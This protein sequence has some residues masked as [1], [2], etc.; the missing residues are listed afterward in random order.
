MGKERGKKGSDENRW[1][2]MVGNIRVEREGQGRKWG[3]WYGKKIRKDGREKIN[4][5]IRKE[6]DEIRGKKGR[7]LKKW[8]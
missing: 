2:R 1:H 4:H 8:K 7:E 6:M 3:K 5:H